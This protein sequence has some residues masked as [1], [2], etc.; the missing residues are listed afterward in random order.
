M[1][2]IGTGPSLPGSAFTGSPSAPRATIFSAGAATPTH[3]PC[4]E[5]GLAA[6]PSPTPPTVNTN[7]AYHAGVT[8]VCTCCQPRG[9]AGSDGSGGGFW[10]QSPPV[11]PAAATT[12]APMTFTAKLTAAP[13]VDSSTVLPTLKQAASLMLITPAPRLAAWTTARARLRTDAAAGVAL[14]SFLSVLLSVG[15][16]ASDAW[17]SEIRRASGATPT[18]PSVGAGRPAMME[19]TRVPWASQSLSPS[20]SA[21]TKSPP[22]STGTRG[23]AFT[24]VSMMATVTPAPVANLCASATPR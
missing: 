20:P 7:G 23:D 18:K 22:G 24:P 19:A 14:G 9:S 16:N 2:A 17:R 12:T 15:S 13:R 10:P 5:N 1:P 4:I 8:M 6:P 11:L 21:R 3:G